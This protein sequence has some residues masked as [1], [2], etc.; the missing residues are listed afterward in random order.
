MRWQELSVATTQEAAESVANLFYEIGA[1][2]VVIQDPQD[3]A[4]YLSEA[5]WEAYE[6]SP[7]VLEA[8]H[9]VVKAYLPLNS[10]LDNRISFLRM[11][12]AALDDHF[13]D[14]MAEL[15]LT[16]IS[17]EDWSQSWKTFYHPEKV[18]HRIVVAPAWEKYEPSEDELVIWLDPGMAFGT[19]THPT[20]AM[21]IRL[22][23]RYVSPGAKVIDVGTGSGV[24]AIAAARLGAGQVTGVDIDPLAVTI[25]R[26]NAAA[27]RLEDRVMIKETDLLA[28]VLCNANLIVAN[29][30][31]DPVMLLIPQAHQCL[32]S[33]G[34]LIVSGI[35][36]HRLAEVQSALLAEG[37][38]IIELE[39][40]D[41]W[42]AMVCQKE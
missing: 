27:N 21:C 15:S 8:E 10:S 13:P 38:A 28:G 34:F 6:I 11:Q 26:E 33:G 42:V 23:E 4:R 14:F 7:D 19:G 39:R 25:A 41:E 30:V 5:A 40:Q 3:I 12:L 31:A 37:F 20:T 24:L 17:E 36:R 32:L 22:L 18:G 2:G 35:I 29:I 9:V 16:E 1:T